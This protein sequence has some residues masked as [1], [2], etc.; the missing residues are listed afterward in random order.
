MHYTNR[1][2]PVRLLQ[3]VQELAETAGGELAEHIA[4]INA[5]YPPEVVEHYSPQYADKL[6]LLIDGSGQEA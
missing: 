5:C 6:M 4:A 2:C 3:L 1:P